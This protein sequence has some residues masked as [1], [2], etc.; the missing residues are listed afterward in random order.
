MFTGFSME[1]RQFLMELSVN[2]YKSWFEE[3]REQY[4]NYLK[5]PFDALAKEVMAAMAE[6]F[7]EL[8]M[9]LHISRIYRD[10]R[11]LFGRGPYKDHM[12]F[13]LDPFISG[14]GPGLYFEIGPMKWSM[15]M[16][17]WGDAPMM[18]R[19]RRYMLHHEEVFTDFNKRLAGQDFFALEGQLYKREKGQVG[20][21]LKPWYN[22]K[23]LWIGHESVFDR[24]LCVPELKDELVERFSFLIPFYKAFMEAYTYGDGER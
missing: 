24:R 11:R 16:G 2:N 1:T 13:S 15:G 9:K 18:N 5:T 4:Q 19:L 21:E 20:D 14:E 6:K 3:H 12:W 7:P 8:P 22:R 23:T 10:A 17:C